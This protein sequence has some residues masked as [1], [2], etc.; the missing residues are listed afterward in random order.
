MHVPKALQ[1]FDILNVATSLVPLSAIMI[2][3]FALLC[4][5]SSRQ[6]K[7]RSYNN[8]KNVCPTLQPQFPAEHAR[9][10]NNLGKAGRSFNLS[11]FVFPMS[12]SDR[13]RTHTHGNFHLLPTEFHPVQ[14]QVKHLTIC[15]S[16]ILSKT[17]RAICT[18]Y[19]RS[20]TRTFSRKD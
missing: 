2:K 1:N 19:C 10:Y 9:S 6:N 5:L 17:L 15:F 7:A 13:D 4:N 20:H 8:L 14:S 12:L 3:A 18:F 11:T 16:P